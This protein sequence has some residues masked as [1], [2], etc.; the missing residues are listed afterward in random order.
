MLDSASLLF[1]FQY[2]EENECLGRATTVED[3]ILSSVR[4][5]LITRKGSR[6]G[7]NLGSF[8]TELLYQGIP[9]SQLPNLSAELKKELEGQFP[10]VN[11]LD[12][13]LERDL[14]NNTSSLNVHITL[15]VPVASGI[16][17][18]NMSLPSVFNN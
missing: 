2:D 16:F 8:L 6:V 11:F 12:V 1:P 9:L 13:V 18:V 5:F 14:S 4:A 3:T 7:S 17:E 10:G 15:S